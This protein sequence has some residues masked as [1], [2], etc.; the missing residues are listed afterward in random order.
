MGLLLCGN[1][2]YGLCLT[3]SDNSYMAMGSVTFLDFKNVKD[4][5][6]SKIKFFTM[7]KTNLPS[8]SEKGDVE[9]SYKGL[10]LKF[11]ND[12]KKRNLIC[13]CDNFLDGQKLQADIVLSDF[14]AESMVIATPFKEDKKA[15]Y[16]NQKI[17]CMKA[18]G[19]VVISDKEYSFDN[20]N[21]LGLLDWGRGVW[22]NTWYW[23]VFPGIAR[24]QAF[25]FN[26]GYGFGDLGGFKN[27]LPRTAK[28]IA[29]LGYLIFP[30]KTERRLYFL[31]LTSDDGRFEMNFEP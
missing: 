18:S 10:Y 26:I 17:N 5:T 1:D 29:F 19:K 9:Q 25:G 16:Y 24:R 3:I 2:E 23:A 7:G 13:E 21:S 27:M 28:R 12:G 30:S 31:D 11:T 20:N 8:T 22:T 15:F 4:T 14:P 6:V